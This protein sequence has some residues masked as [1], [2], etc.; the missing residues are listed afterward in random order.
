MKNI[1]KKALASALACTMA[2]CMSATAFAEADKT[3][4][5]EGTTGGEYGYGSSVLTTT[6]NPSYIMTIPADLTITYGATSTNWGNVTA[7]EIHLEEGKCIRATIEVGDKENASVSL[8]RLSNDMSEVGFLRSGDTEVSYIRYNITN[9]APMT[10]NI[11]EYGYYFELTGDMFP[12]SV[13]I[14]NGA[15]ESARA[16]TYKDTVNFSFEVDYIC[17]G[18]A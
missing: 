13:K 7:A 14:D 8:T 2:L 16:G 3:V 15:W 11:D 18:S 17:N 10:S 9:T 6:V 4:A 12:L 5:I 1:M